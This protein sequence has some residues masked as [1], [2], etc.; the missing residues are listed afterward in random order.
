MP[1]KKS[2]D[3]ATGF[4]GSASQ[5]LDHDGYEGEWKSGKFDGRGT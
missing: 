4:S 1:K 3:G 5:R 2:S